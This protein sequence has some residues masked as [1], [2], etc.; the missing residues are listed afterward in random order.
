MPAYGRALLD[1][2][3]QRAGWAGFHPAQVD[4]VYGDDW[5][6]AATRMALE[7]AVFVKDGLDARPYQARW[8]AEVGIPMLAI[9]PREYGYGVFDFRCVAGCAVRVFDQAHGAGDY[10]KVPGVDFPGEAVSRW[11]RFYFLLGEIAAYA[12]SVTLHDKPDGTGEDVADY[13]YGVRHFDGESRRW[14]FPPWWS[15]ALHQRLHDASIDWLLDSG[16]EAGLSLND[17]TAG[18]ASR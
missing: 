5:R 4:L 7:K 17:E 14:V 3:R 12:A 18:V 2:R 11:G 1:N 15:A 16:R 9:R 8:L 13:A 10:D 6:E